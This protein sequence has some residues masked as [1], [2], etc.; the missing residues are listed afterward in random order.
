MT[1]RKPPDRRRRHDELDEAGRVRKATLIIIATY[2]QQGYS[3]AA[4]RLEVGA[5]VK[6]A[7]T[8]PKPWKSMAA[9]PGEPA[10][11]E[12]VSAAG[13]YR[14]IMERE[15]IDRDDQIRQETWWAIAQGTLDEALG[16]AA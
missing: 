5:A 6:E 8:G 1:M 10:P 15:G 14:L 9:I 13:V 12:V 16:P 7:L 4:I 11:M 2:K 3:P